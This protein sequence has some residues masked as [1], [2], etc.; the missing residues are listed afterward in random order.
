[1]FPRSGIGAPSPNANKQCPEAYLSMLTVF[2]GHVRSTEQLKETR[3]AEKQMQKLQKA[4][5]TTKIAGIAYIAKV[6]AHAAFTI[7]SARTADITAFVAVVE[8]AG[9]K[10]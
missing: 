9:I 3:L 1:M 4:S 8:V 5:T 6:L 10:R 7:A 2:A